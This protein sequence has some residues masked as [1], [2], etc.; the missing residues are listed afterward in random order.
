M[1][2][3]EGH[4][5]RIKQRVNVRSDGRRLCEKCDRSRQLE[6]E[7]SDDDGNTPRHPDVS[8]GGACANRIVINELLAYCTYHAKGSTCEAIK[9][10]IMDFYTPDEI[11]TA[12][13]TMWQE[14]GTDVL[15]PTPSRQ[16]SPNRSAHEVEIDDLLNAVNVID[17]DAGH[18]MTFVAWNLGRLP[19][20]APEELDLTSVILRLTQL[21]RKHEYLERKVALNTDQVTTMTEVQLQTTSY[22]GAVKRNAEHAAVGRTAP[23]SANSTS[24][25]NAVDVIIDQTNQLRGRSSTIPELFHR[26]TAMADSSGTDGDVTNDAATG[27]FVRPREQR[28]REARQGKRPTRQQ[29]FGSSTSE[30]LKA[31]KRTREFFVFNLDGDTT[32]DDL[33]KF[34]IDSGIQAPNIERKSNEDAT[35]KSFRIVIDSNDAEKI[36]RPELWPR[37]VGVR[38]YYNRSKRATS[39]GRPT[40]E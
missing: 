33:S 23:Q 10:V 38:P 25:L 37:G 14:Y 22:S 34:L 6:D 12:K 19:R 21:E 20:V 3:C 11:T 35:N 40:Q 9:R 32:Q 30:T 13:N 7:A 18:L 15:G 39:A 26:S 8:E 27:G 29:V 36:M 24:N 2:A 5:C 1:P 28:L 16:D 31:G 4:N 17:R